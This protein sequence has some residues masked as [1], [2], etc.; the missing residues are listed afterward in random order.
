MG[1]CAPNLNYLLQVTTNFPT[2][3]TTPAPRPTTP[4]TCEPIS[5][6][7]CKDLPYNQTRF[8]NLLN[9]A[10]QEIANLEIHQFFPLLKAKCSPVLRLFLCSVHAPVC[11]VLPEIVKPCRSLCNAARQGCKRLMREYGFR[12]PARLSCK[13]FPEDGACIKAP[14]QVMS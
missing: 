8:P 3:T 9:H 14:Q 4:P 7:L 6:R 12:W 10:S 11:S 13:K 5:I 2:A 1:K